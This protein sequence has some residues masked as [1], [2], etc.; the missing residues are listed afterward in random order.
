MKVL[1]A[2]LY[3]LLLIVFFAFYGALGYIAV[4][5]SATGRS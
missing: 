3:A 5:L 1:K 4:I 2:L